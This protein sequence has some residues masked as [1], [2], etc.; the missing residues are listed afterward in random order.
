MGMLIVCKDLCC[1]T[2]SN[3]F[4]SF[5]KSKYREE[6]REER[7][8]LTLIV[9][10]SLI[11]RINVW[12]WKLRNPSR[13]TCKVKSR[14]SFWIVLVKSGP[15]SAWTAGCQLSGATS[16]TPHVSP[17]SWFNM[18]LS[19]LWLPIYQIVI[20]DTPLLVMVRRIFYLL[21]ENL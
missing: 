4:A 3:I 13:H 17:F 12:Y 18:H 21:Y 15:A 7:T 11:L 8:C 20:L 2:V 16:Y 10:R 5:C 1:W 14:H 6:F 19:L 9:E